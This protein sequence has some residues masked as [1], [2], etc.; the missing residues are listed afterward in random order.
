MGTHRTPGTCPDFARATGV[1][2]RYSEQHGTVRAVADWSQ[3][4]IDY[5]EHRVGHSHPYVADWSQ[6]GIDY[7]KSAA[8]SGQG[9]VADW[10][11]DGI[12]YTKCPI[13]L[14]SVSVADWSQDGIDYT[15][16]RLLGAVRKV[17]DWSQDGI[18]Y[19]VPRL[20]VATSGLRIG[21]RTG[22][23]TLPDRSAGGSRRCGL[24]AGRDRLHCWSSP[25][26]R[27]RKLR[28]GRRT[29]STTL[30]WFALQR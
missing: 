18:D 22:S 10:S 12:D 24:V 13:T 9:T 26:L 11:Q 16:R 29:G 1:C 28:I 5:T 27:P 6:D 20:G 25:A 15:A 21:R 30:S 23:T 3:D 17:A 14:G 4:G 8:A 19:T 7:T 2:V